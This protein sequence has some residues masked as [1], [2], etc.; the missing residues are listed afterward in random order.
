[1]LI[2][3]NI[4]NVRKCAQGVALTPALQYHLAGSAKLA[5]VD[6]SPPVGQ[7]ADVQDRRVWHLAVGCRRNR[8]LYWEGIFERGG[9]G[10]GPEK[11]K[12]QQ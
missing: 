6:S 1:M 10:S 5:V 12:A 11:L 3:T 2:Q 9:R 8:W 4:A 7:F